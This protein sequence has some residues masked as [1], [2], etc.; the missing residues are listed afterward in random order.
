MVSEEEK[1][2]VVQYGSLISI[3]FIAIRLKVLITHAE[4]CTADKT[5]IIIEQFCIFGV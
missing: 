1:V 5:L 2:E 4:L 3:N